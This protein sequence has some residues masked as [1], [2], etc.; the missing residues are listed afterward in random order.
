MPG[1]KTRSVALL[2][3]AV[4]L[5]M[6][7][8]FVSAA[9][10]PEM[11]AEAA[12]GPGRAAALSSA[13]QL[14]FVAGALALAAQ[15]TADRYDPRRVFALCA[16]LAAAANLAL[17]AFPTGGAVQIGL[18]ALTGAA[19][20]GVYPVGMKIAVGWGARDRG[21]LVGLIVAAVT[22]GSASP[23]LIALAGGADWRATVVATSALAAVGG[24]RARGAGRGP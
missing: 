6:S 18:R 23:H 17:L 8:W 3:L 5:A 11:T 14:G 10:L 22:L 13:V 24:A 7:L 4:T 9:I 20:A 2:A 19:L 16:L 21:L 15:G 1:A 12:L